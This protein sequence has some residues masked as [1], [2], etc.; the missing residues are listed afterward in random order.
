MKKSKVWR[1]LRTNRSRRGSGRYRPSLEKLEDR[2]PL[3]AEFSTLD[4][5]SDGYLSAVDALVIVNAVNQNADYEG[6]HDVNADK[7]VSPVDALLVINAINAQGRLEGFAAQPPAI[8][9]FGVSVDPATELVQFDSLATS[10]HGGSLTYGWDFGDGSPVQSGINLHQITHQ[11]TQPG[12][13]VA[14]LSVSDSS[15][16][17]T[18]RRQTVLVVAQRT[19]AVLQAPIPQY[20]GLASVDLQTSMGNVTRGDGQGVPANEFVWEVTSVRSSQ[21]V[22]VSAQPTRA[23]ATPW[24]EQLDASAQQAVVWSADH[25]EGNLDDWTFPDFLYAGGGIFNTSEPNV[26]VQADDQLSFTGAYAARAHI[27]GALQGNRRAVRLMRWTDRPYDDAGTELPT[28]AFY[29]TWIY[30]PENYAPTDFWNVFQ[31]KSND[32]DLS[33]GSESGWSTNIE[34]NRTSG[35]MELY[36]FAHVPG[37]GVGGTSYSQTSPIPV[38][39]GR[40][41]HLEAYYAAS[42]EQNGRISLWQDGHKI[43]DV[44]NVRTA[45]PAPSNAMLLSPAARDLLLSFESD[46]AALDA[47]LA[48]PVQRNSLFAEVRDYLLRPVWGIGNYTDGIAGGARDGDVTMHFDDAMIASR[49]VSNVASTSFLLVQLNAPPTLSLETNNL[50]VNRDQT[51][52]VDV[53][54]TD[55]GMDDLWL[56]A[57]D[58]NG[59]PVGQVQRLGYEVD[60]SV[61]WRW[62]WSQPP[63]GSHEIQFQVNDGSALASDDL[64]LDVSSVIKRPVAYWNFDGDLLDA[65][66]DGQ[67]ADQASLVGNASLVA[68]GVGTGSLRLNGGNDQVVIGS[69]PDINQGRID[70]WSL[71]LWFKAD[72]PSASQRQVLYQQGGTVRGLNLYIEGGQLI[73]G[74]WDGSQASWIS[75]ALDSAQWHHVVLSLDAQAQQLRLYLDGKLRGTAVTSGIRGHNAATLGAASAGSRYL[76]TDHPSGYVS[77]TATFPLTGFL[78][79]VRV[80]RR[81]L[82]RADARNLA[83]QQ[84]TPDLQTQL[85]AHWQFEGQAED[86]APTG[87]QAD[88]VQLQGA[89][90]LALGGLGTQ[91]LVLAGAGDF[92][93]VPT[94]PDING[95]S[96]EQHTIALWFRPEDLNA[97]GRQVLYQQGGTARGLNIYLENGS[98]WA[99]AWGD[100][101]SG[102]W[103]SSNIVARRWQHVA[104]VLDAASQQMSLFVDG[105]LMGTRTATSLAAHNAASIGGS[106]Q[107]SR[108]ASQAG[109]YVNSIS[110]HTFFGTVDDV[111]VYRRSLSAAEVAAL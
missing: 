11:Y 32:I 95:T 40:W 15:Q 41:F 38:P 1:D 78:D 23:M 87:S 82:H 91:T 43:L 60:G 75:T 67:V 18:T 55:A 42:A 50:R 69:S 22:T 61:I 74:G 44:T 31:F 24:L 14:Q 12:T 49:R 80:F 8:K 81:P 105:V 64:Q 16:L 68:E 27:S 96:V 2:L 86:T 98:L 47:L 53:I 85:T 48:D 72:N 52:I 7:T 99:G 35:Q 54:T 100:G 9:R 28:K 26:Q 30:I 6:R 34:Y 46:P 79:E 77:S 10:S 73:G 17:T 39:V 65:A 36:L 58:S 70:Q 4:V 83:I 84:P 93:S 66:V 56:S 19:P 88:H 111:R 33:D 92:A 90:T 104:L 25:E 5:N 51:A 59:Q 21:L 109:G 107:G 3:T 103:I 102:D 108:F 20:S 97:P 76:D 110:T 106:Q 71:S 37:D 13:Y 62:S 29:S 101:W 45:Q 57:V 94:S 89:A 63:V